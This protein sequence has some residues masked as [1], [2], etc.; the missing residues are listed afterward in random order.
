MET[1]TLNL[2]Q[3]KK[4][5]DKEGMEQTQWIRI[6]KL[7]TKMGIPSSIKLDCYP[8]PDEKGEVWLKVFPKDNKDN[9]FENATLESDIAI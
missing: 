5:I 3:A 7:F 6:G 4:Y 2:T 8:I 1:E 9:N